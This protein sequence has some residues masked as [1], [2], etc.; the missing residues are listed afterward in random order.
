MPL[1]R[2]ATSEVEEPLAGR[3][4]FYCVRAVAVRS[5][6]LW[7]PGRVRVGG[8]GVA[9]K[10][11]W[12]SW[13]VTRS[14]SFDITA[15]PAGEHV[16]GE[17]GVDSAGPGG[18]VGE[19]R[20]PQP[21]R[22]AGRELAFDQVRGAHTCGAYDLTAADAG[23][24]QAGAS[25]ARPGRARPHSTSESPPNRGRFSPRA[26]PLGASG[27]WLPINRPI[28]DTDGFSGG[29]TDDKL[30]DLWWWAW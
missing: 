6:R 25:A 24:G 18:D 19:V 27:V 1:S 22:R 5:S 11:S 20:D 17:G 9:R 14:V 21:V 16:D 2:R 3:V 15:R 12:R 23:A 26:Q 29:D 7:A 4:A 28:M 13:S 10:G 30:S 8:R